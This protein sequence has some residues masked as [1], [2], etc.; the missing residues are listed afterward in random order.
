MTTDVDVQCLDTFPTWLRS[1]GSD[2]EALVEALEH[3]DTPDAARRALAGGL[4]Y[5]FKSVDLIPDGIDDIGY[6]DDAFVLRLATRLA[7]EAG[8]SLEGRAVLAQLVTDDGLVKTFLGRDYGRLE[9]YVRGLEKGS[10]RGRGVAEILSSA[11]VRGD[12]VADVHGFARSYAAPSF[13]REEK[14]LIKLRAFFDAKLP[15]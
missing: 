15:H 13:S 12:F 14:N 10:A 8:L 9:Q 5:V 6:L 3:G 4:N 1:L 11:S 7:Q 2:A